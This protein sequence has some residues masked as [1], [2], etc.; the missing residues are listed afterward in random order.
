[1]S[2][3]DETTNEASIKKCCNLQFKM[4]CLKDPNFKDWF[5]A[6]QK[7]LV[8]VSAAR[9][10]LEIQTGRRYYDEDSDR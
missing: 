3:S 5:V 1:M 2:S 7:I 10:P 8:I 9:S 4:E 6:G